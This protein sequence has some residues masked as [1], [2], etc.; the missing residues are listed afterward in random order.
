[1][2]EDPGTNNQLGKADSALKLYKTVEIRTRDILIQVDTITQLSYY[3]QII[4]FLFS[5]TILAYELW[6]CDPTTDFFDQ[7]TFNNWP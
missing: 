3:S 6:T 4:P 1:M 7:K 5:R 2:K